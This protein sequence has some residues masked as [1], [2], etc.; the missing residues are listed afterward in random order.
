M[1]VDSYDDVIITNFLL[2]NSLCNT[3]AFPDL[4]VD[5]GLGNF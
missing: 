3:G 5:A 2:Y 1:G 4:G